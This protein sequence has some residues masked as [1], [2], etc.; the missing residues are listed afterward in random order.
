MTFIV[1]CDRSLEK[2]KTDSLKDLQRKSL[3]KLVDGQDVFFIQP[4]WS[5]NL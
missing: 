3:K 5:E 2:F 4:T 1:A